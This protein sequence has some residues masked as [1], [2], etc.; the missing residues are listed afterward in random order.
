VTH[1]FKGVV[2]INDTISIYHTNGSCNDNFDVLHV[3]HIIYLIP[4]GD[5]CYTSS[6]CLKNV[7]ENQSFYGMERDSL[8]FI[9]NSISQRSKGEAPLP[10]NYSIVSETVLND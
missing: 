10:E 6:I 1:F 9:S 8:L 3:K 7:H 2:D 5:N 4:L